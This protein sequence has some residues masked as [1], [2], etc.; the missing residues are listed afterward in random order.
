MEHTPAIP[1]EAGRSLRS[2]E[3][4]AARFRALLR[5]V[6]RDPP[7]ARARRVVLLVVVIWIV[8]LFDLALT[9]LAEQIGGF[10]EANPIVARITHIWGLLAAF[11]LFTLAFASAIFIKYRRERFTEWGCWGMCIVHVLLALLWLRYYAA[12]H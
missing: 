1:N 8:G 2:S 7:A 11:K 10:V 9:L 3:G 5:G 6:S 4:L 12:F